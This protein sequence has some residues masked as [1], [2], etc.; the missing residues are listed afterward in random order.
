MRLFVMGENVWRNEAAWPPPLARPLTLYLGEKTGPPRRILSK[1]APES[2]SSSSA[3]VSDPQDPVTDPFAAEAGAHDYRA[4]VGRK[5]LLV[6]ETEPFA[7]E[8]RVRRTHQR[9]D[10]RL[11]RRARHRLVAEA[12]R[13]GSG[14]HRL[15][16]DEPRPRRAPRELSRRGIRA[17]TPRARPGGTRCPSRTS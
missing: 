9:E 6:F 10:P 11:H 5:D 8:T 1:Q 16:P 17:K 14:R 4:L 2:E 7:A 3:F 15:E 13:R 12:L